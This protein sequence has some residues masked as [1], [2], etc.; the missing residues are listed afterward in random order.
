MGTNEHTVKDLAVKD[1]AVESVA[2]ELGMHPET[3]RRLLLAGHLPG[4]KAGRHWRVTRAVLDG[5]KAS[6]GLRPVGRPGKETK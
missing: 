1:M 5:F 2:A 4:Y 3:I 6:G